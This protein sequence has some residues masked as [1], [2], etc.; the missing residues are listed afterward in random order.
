MDSFLL[1]VA[2]RIAEAHP[3][4]TDRTLVVVNNRRS[5]RFFQRQFLTLGR[6]M[7]LP[8]TMVIDE[9]IAELGGMEVVPSEFLL[10]ELYAI[11]MQ[12][13]GEARKYKTFDEFI[14]FG[15]LMVADFSEVDQYCV[16]ARDLFNNLHDQKVLGEW[17]IENSRLT[18]FQQ[19]YLRFYR[20]LYDYYR[21]LRERLEAQGK[22]YS[23][24]AYRRVAEHIDTLADRV[25]A[26]MV[27]FVGFNAM[28]ECERRII[29][30]FV[31]RGKGVLFTDTDAYYLQPEQEA[32]HFLRKHRAEFPSLNPQGQSLFSQGQRHITIVECPENL[33]Q[34][35][36]AGGLL[37]SHP[38]WMA[39]GVQERTAVVLADESL[40][41]PTLGSLPEGDYGVNI[42]MGYSFCDSHMHLLAQRLL[43]LHATA[44]EQGFRYR[45]VIDLLGDRYVSRLIGGAA[46]R[47]EAEKTMRRNNIIRCSG[48][49]LRAMLNGYDDPTGMFSAQATGDVEQWLGM[50]QRLVAALDA[51]G[52]LEH[53]HKERQA[54]GSLAEMLNY[55]LELQHTYHYIDSLPTLRKIYLRLAR[56][57]SVALIG[58]PLSGLQVMGMLETRNLDFDRVVLLS[59]GEGVLPATRASSSLIPHELRMAFHMPTR[60]EKDSVY[61]FNF[62]H[63]LLRSTD[64][65]LVYSSAAE[66]MG[67]GEPSRF[68]SQ[69]EHEL[70]P[71]FGIEVEHVVINN[72]QPRHVAATPA[73]RQMAKSAAVMERLFAMADHGFSPTGFESYL[74]CPLSFYYTHV[75]GIGNDD[76]MDDDLDASQLGTAIHS[77][78]EEVY[79]PWVGRR[80]PAEALRKALAD[81]PMLLD[82]VFASLFSR[83]RTTAGRNSFYRGVAETQVRTLLA[84]EEALLR[85]GHTIEIVGLE[86]TLGPWQF[87]ATPEGRPVRLKGKADR[88]D[89]YDGQWLRVIDYKSGGLKDTETAYRSTPNR[90][91][92]IKVEG[93]WFQLMCYA[94]LYNQQPHPAL[95]LQ[96]GIYP[97][98]HL[99]S[100]VKVATFDGREVI[101]NEELNYFRQLLTDQCLELLDPSL[102]FLATTRRD[103]CKYCDARTFCPMHP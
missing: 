12:L 80:V 2:R 34:C 77:A 15:D 3:N 86:Q 76:A 1:S 67:K 94:L 64:V 58:E 17:N 102:P 25:D 9:L 69:V 35:K 84:R 39:A 43:D 54:A 5:M 83:G 87:A 71:R 36:Y 33:L 96:A 90:N 31:R 75:L 24:M 88:I 55:L 98:R 100:G 42:S 57:H 63:L 32:G 37:Q 29:G 62:Y 44:N 30:E 95:P 18:P 47:S 14:S 91:G 22:A 70:A 6:T 23:G 79:G 99:Q 52:M 16:D 10:F 13:E 93:K 59:V 89:I 65:Y 68:I 48:D 40:L 61:A 103:D 56:H 66:T 78:L 38:E 82:R 20:R 74:N 101:G 41:L 97:L 73:G 7:F 19:D 51:A 45:E 26:D 49:E 60:Q 46:L 4:D 50:M 28:S 81:L 21:L 85:E 11:H 53:N 92:E 27:Y 8:R 72:N